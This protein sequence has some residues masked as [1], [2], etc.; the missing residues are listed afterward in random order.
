MVQ[1]NCSISNICGFASSS[2]DASLYIIKILEVHVLLL[3]Y[4]DDLIMTDNDE[5][6]MNRLKDELANHFK[7]KNLGTLK[8]FLGL[9]VSRCKEGVFFFSGTICQKVS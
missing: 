2:S 6:E 5:Q 7:M 1:K 3:L 8:H 4:V 9:E